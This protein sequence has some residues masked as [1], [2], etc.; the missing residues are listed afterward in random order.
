[1]KKKLFLII[2]GILLVIGLTS[3]DKRD[4]K[5]VK[6]EITIKTDKYEMN[7]IL[8]LP[9]SN[10]KKKFPVVILVGGSG[11]TNMDSSTGKLTPFKDISESLALQGIASLRY[12][13]RTFEYLEELKNDYYFNIEDEY[14]LDALQAISLLSNDKR[15]DKNNLFLLGHSQGGQIAPIIV[16][17]TDKIKGIIIMAGTTSHILDVLME[18]TLK[19]QGEETYNEYLEYAEIAK[20][21]TTPDNTKHQHFYFG[22]YYHYWVAYN[23][24]NFEEE[25][26][27]AAK[28]HPILIMYGKKDLQ[29]FPHHYEKY[30]ILL[31]NDNYKNVK[32]VSYPNLNHLFTDAIDETFNTMY[33]FNR[34]VDEEVINDIINFILNGS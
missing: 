4:A 5:I 19:Y 10:K 1:M 11:P 13:K 34:K 24:I 30:Q 6:E 23:K 28:T 32:F 27:T 15:I 16:N 14:I 29:V 18:Q 20:N 33:S 7:G 2:F 8:T 25:L 3:C 12:N 31:P 22:A 17:R 26:V 9:F 21:I